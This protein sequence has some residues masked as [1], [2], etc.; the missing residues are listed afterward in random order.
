MRIN[1]AAVPE[2]WF[3]ALGFMSVCLSLLMVVVWREETQLPWWGILFATALG[4]AF[5]LPL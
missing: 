2:W 1:Y 3:V 5:T 4:A